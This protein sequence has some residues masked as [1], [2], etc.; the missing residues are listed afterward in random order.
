MWLVLLRIW[1]LNFVYIE[2]LN[3]VFK[4]NWLLGASAYQ[5]GQCRSEVQNQS[6]EIRGQCSLLRLTQPQA[7]WVLLTTEIILFKFWNI[8]S[9]C[10]LILRHLLELRKTRYTLV[11]HEIKCMGSNQHFIKNVIHEIEWKKPACITFTM[12]FY[13]TG[14]SGW[15]WGAYV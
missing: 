4:F 13:E 5:I 9:F 12:L 15:G 1:I 6:L 3:D 8:S 2:N 14:I 7:V 10:Y 11:V